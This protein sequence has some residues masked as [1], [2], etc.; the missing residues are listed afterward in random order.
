MPG[1]ETYWLRRSIDEADTIRWS[2]RR[3]PIAA[4]IGAPPELVAELGLPPRMLDGFI[5]TLAVF[6]I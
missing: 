6:G 5:W 1:S 2:L 4:V 3:E